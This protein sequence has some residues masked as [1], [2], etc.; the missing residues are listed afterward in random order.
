[1]KMKWNINKKV[2]IVIST[3]LIFNKTI[4]FKT[5]KKPTQKC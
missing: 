5:L 4:T 1:M 2:F 3:L